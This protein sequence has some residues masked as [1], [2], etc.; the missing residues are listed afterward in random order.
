[1]G[2]FIKGVHG[3]FSG[4]IGHVIGAAWRG[5]DYMKSLPRKSN[6]PATQ[7]QLTQRLIFK[8]VVGFFRPIN[9]LIKIGYQSYRGTQTPINAVVAYHIE[10]AVTGIYPNLGIDFPKVRF[11][12]GHLLR[13]S[14]VGVESVA[15]AKVKFDW[16]N[17]TPP[18]GTSTAAT[19]LATLLV[20]NPV[21]ELFLSVEDIAARSA[22][23]FTLPV[24]ADWI[25]DDVHCW[26][27]FVS[28]SRKE[29]SDSAY[30]GSTAVL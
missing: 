9:N 3:G 24:P 15:T 2:T 21:K 5:V 6:K 17:N 27:S 30:V 14:V 13:P 8:M 26:M 4:K 1:M 12:K 20:Y 11:S 22:L 28:V 10:K 29:V 16:L 23:S 25:G 18:I 7:A 19:D